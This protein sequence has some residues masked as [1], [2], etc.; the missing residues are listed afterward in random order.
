MINLH[1]GC[2]DKKLDGFINIDIRKTDATDI[3][4][5]AWKI[6]NI[7]NLTVKKIYSRHM[8]EHLDPNDA[9]LTLNHWFN[10]LR[11]DGHLN[12]IVPDIE[13]HSKQ[14]LGITKSKK[15]D[16]EIQH[17]FAGFW[18][19]RDE[20][21]GG[22]KEDAHKWGYTEK[23]LIK[24]L[25]NAGF[26]SIKRIYQGKDTEAYHLNL[27]ATKSETSMNALKYEYNFSKKWKI[28]FNK[29]ILFSLLLSKL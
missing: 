1:V 22:N 20:N 4:S 29:S 9:R 23:S 19:W 7:K 15:F 14:L 12:I 11:K 21:R 8:L 10:L 18:G 17:S 13:F 24:E 3:V 28:Y 27:V 5:P 2:A 26:K 25:K 16:D 6:P